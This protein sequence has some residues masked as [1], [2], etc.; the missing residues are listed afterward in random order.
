MNK[1]TLPE[2]LLDKIKKLLEIRADRG[3]TENEVEQA[4]L[5]ASRL[6]MKHNL[7]MYD[8]ESHDSRVKSGIME[9][10]FNVD[11]WQSK[12]DGAWVLRLCQFL[13]NFNLCHTLHKIFTDKN[14]QGHII[15]IGKPQNVEIVQYLTV[16]LIVKIEAIYKVRWKEYGGIEKR[17]TF[18]RGYCNGVV[19]GIAYKLR[20][21]QED[22]EYEA[23]RAAGKH[24]PSSQVWP[25]SNPQPRQ[26]TMAL[27]VISN[28]DQI[29]KFIKETHPNVKFIKSSAKGKTK[30]GFDGRA[31]GFKD[32]KD[33]NINQGLGNR[34]N[35]GLIN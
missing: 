14:H 5:M 24:Q 1:E 15:I 12:T 27:M 28:N 25:P 7:T 29:E 17:N 18:R 6:L 30:K 16:Q 2:G 13:A 3:A 10:I 22:M 31:Q 35:S 34:D 23:E 33:M 8:V 4:A 9:D 19:N 11:E 20:Q 21:Q 26:N 32:G